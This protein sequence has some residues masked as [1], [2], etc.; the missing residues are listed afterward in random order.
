[1]RESTR[2]LSQTLPRRLAA[3]T[4]L[5]SAHATG[6][7]LTLEYEIGDVSTS[8]A[9]K[10]GLTPTLARLRAHACS[11]PGTRAVLRRGGMLESVYYDRA[12]KPIAR[13]VV[14]ERDCSADVRYET[15]AS[16]EL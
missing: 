13:L 9:N 5:T 12:R 2:R 6:C 10:A 8:Q 7:Q 14:S 1:M 16:A 15:S 3:H 11:S 4:S